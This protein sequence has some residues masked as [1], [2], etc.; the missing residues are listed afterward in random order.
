[1]EMNQPNDPKVQELKDRLDAIDNAIEAK[2]N[3]LID[4]GMFQF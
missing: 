3:E 4:L 2:E 1:M